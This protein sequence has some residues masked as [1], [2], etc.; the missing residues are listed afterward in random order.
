M[1]GKVV[2]LGAGAVG[3]TVATYLRRHTGHSITVFSS[4][5]HTAYSQCGMPFVLEGVI[6]DFS[7]LIVRPRDAFI[8]MGIDLHLETTINHID[9]TGQKVISDAGA[10]GY[11]YLVI[12]T[13]SVPFVPPVKGRELDGVFTLHTLSD[14]MK[15]HSSINDGNH[16]V[17]IGAGGIGT[18]LAASLAVRGIDVTLVEALPQV[19]PLTM[20][21]DMALLVQQHLT[22]LGVHVVTGVQVDSINGYGHV[23]SVTIQGDTVPAGTVPSDIV[24]MATGLRPLSSIAQNAGYKIGITGGIVTDEHLRVSADAGI[25]DNVYAGGECAEVK[26]F[27]TGS[28]FISR[29]GSAA[30]RMARVIGENI[31]GDDAVYPP[32]LSPNVVVAG[33][34]TAGSVGITS[35]TAALNDISVVCGISKGST[36]AGY[37]P[38]GSQLTVKLIFSNRM[39]VGAQVVAGEGVKERIDALSLAIRMG[40]T[41]DDLLEWETAYAP[42]VSMVIDTV[43]FAAD[44]AKRKMRE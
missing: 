15:I 32:T 21:P 31:T 35:H 30:R 9:A 43:T 23:R 10:F 8:D 6:P 14:G 41:V 5:T 18:E 40:A 42:P 17:I 2:I 3:M 22:S 7:D 37:Y 34:L 39:L 12:A 25:Q 33:K 28:P 26:E 20:D 19:L 44:D 27:V 16:V 24:I 11:D 1:T 36:R 38:G 4:D 13:G 29:L